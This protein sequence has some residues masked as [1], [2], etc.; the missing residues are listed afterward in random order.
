MRS[1]TMTDGDGLRIMYSPRLAHKTPGDLEWIENRKQQ[2]VDSKGISYIV[3][4]VSKVLRLADTDTRGRDEALKLW[5]SLFKQDIEK[6]KEPDDIIIGPL[7]LKKHKA[8]PDRKI[9]RD[10]LDYFWTEVFTR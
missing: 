6:E 5:E 10:L 1:F 4:H 9:I 3:P 7:T 2:I 8:W